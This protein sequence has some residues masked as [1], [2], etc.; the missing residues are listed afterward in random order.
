MAA[1]LSMD[2]LESNLKV[3]DNIIETEILNIPN[4]VLNDV[5]D[6]FEV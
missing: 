6:N 4:T 5:I 3:I 2:M 1:V